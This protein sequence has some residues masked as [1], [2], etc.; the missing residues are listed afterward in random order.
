MSQEQ[1]DADQPDDGRYSTLTVG[2][3]LKDCFVMKN[4]E[5][6]ANLAIFNQDRNVTFQAMINDITDTKGQLILPFNMLTHASDHSL[7][8]LDKKSPSQIHNL[9]LDR[10]IVTNDYQLPKPIRG[11]THRFCDDSSDPTFVSFN[12]SDV[13]LIDTRTKEMIVNSSSYKTVNYFSSARTTRNGR[14]AVGSDKGIIRLYGEPCRKRA[15]TNFYI[16]TGNDPITSIDISP[17]E[18][19]VL[20]T[21]NYSISLIPVQIPSTGKLAFNSYMKD[22]KTSAIRLTLSQQDQQAIVSRFNGVPQVFSKAQFICS[23]AKIE[24]IVATYGPAIIRWP[25]KAILNGKI[26]KSQ[27]AYISPEKI[28]DS[29]I[30]DQTNDYV[31][32]S[33]NQISVAYEN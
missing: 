17:D 9:N 14:I 23:G 33:P 27:V 29:N 26:P 24:Y 6:G 3:K 21:C 8:L 22:E 1:N 2:H 7:L 10:T 18:C 13:Q 28:I 31:F 5:S 12:D 20:A 4:Y 25:F 15:T 16:N 30:F 32:I 11:I 19:W